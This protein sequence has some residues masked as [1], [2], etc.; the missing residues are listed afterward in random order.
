MKNSEVL[1]NV[2]QKLSHLPVWEREMLKELLGEFAVLFPDIPGKTTVAVH[3]IDVG[4]TPPIK[5][6]PYRVNPVKLKIM[7]NEIDYW[8]N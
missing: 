2:K 6:H 8:N 7:R 4:D 3:D 5:Q 1:L